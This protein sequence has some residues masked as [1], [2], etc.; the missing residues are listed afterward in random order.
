MEKIANRIAAIVQHNNAVSHKRNENA[1][2]DIGR[3]KFPVVKNLSLLK[4]W[5][6]K[7]RL[8]LLYMPLDNS[9]CWSSKSGWGT[10]F[11]S[12]AAWTV[13]Y[14]WRAAKSNSFILKF[15]LYLNMRKEWLLSI[16]YLSSCLSWSFVLTRCCSLTWVTKVLMRA[17][18][19]P[20]LI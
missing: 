1:V 14:R 16:Y 3:L 9:N 20:L 2:A 15:Y 13:H 18:G 10:Y 12:R 17:A 8:Q 19:Y 5:E 7:M 4:L 11:L 6:L